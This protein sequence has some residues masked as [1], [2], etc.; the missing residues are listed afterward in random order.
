MM[1]LD[2]ARVRPDFLISVGYKW[3]LGPVGLSYLYVDERHHGGEPIEQSWAVR[4]GADDF[5]SL[6]D[7][8]DEY[9]PGARRF[10]VGQRPSFGLVP[11]A[12]AALDQLQAWGIPAVGRSVAAI[13]E[14]IA[15]GLRE[16][17]LPVPPPEARGPHILGVDLPAGTAERVG[18]AL[19]DDR[20]VVSVRGSSLRIG[21]YLHTSDADVDRL[22]VTLATALRARR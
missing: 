14:R 1:P 17:G 12:V 13:T 20:V 9:Q 6:V 18:A 2:L 7:Y 11:M 10:D 5:A 3:Q 22:L 8:R 19:H 21:P 15:G 4:A 16:L